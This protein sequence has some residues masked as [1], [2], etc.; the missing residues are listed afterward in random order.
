MLGFAY[1]KQFRDRQAYAR[2]YEDSVY[3]AP[4]SQRQGVGKVLLAHLL[5]TLK[6][7]GVREVIAVIGDSANS[8]SIA[9][10]KALGFTTTG[11]LRNVGFKFDKW[12]DVVMMQ[13]SLRKDD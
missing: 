4:T 2:T 5:H 9:V 13:R 7:D 3:V 8:G 6:E 12:L 11:V 10:H 1:A